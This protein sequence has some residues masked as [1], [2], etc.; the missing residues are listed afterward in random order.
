MRL[1]NFDLI[2][3]YFVLIN[4]SKDIGSIS[5]GKNTINLNIQDASFLI[6][7]YYYYYFNG[8]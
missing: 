1:N 4:L 5:G 7:N 8:F 3:N 2:I 6:K